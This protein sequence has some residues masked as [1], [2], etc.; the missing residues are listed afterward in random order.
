MEQELRGGTVTAEQI[1]GGGGLPFFISFHFIYTV[2]QTQLNFM[3]WS[4]IL[5]LTV[6]EVVKNPALSVLIR[7]RHRTQSCVIV[8]PVH[9]VTLCLSNISFNIPFLST[10]SRFR[11][12]LALKFTDQTFVWKLD[13]RESVRCDI[14]KKVTN[15]MERDRLIHYS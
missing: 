4:S 8:C 2:Y 5:K 15:K 13:V 1:W 14:N 9:I 11:R 7:A 3:E 6:A 12:P 10:R